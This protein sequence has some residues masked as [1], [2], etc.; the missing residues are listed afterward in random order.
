MSEVSLD[1]Y[2]VDGAILSFNRMLNKANDSLQVNNALLNLEG[3]LNEL[4]FEIFPPKN[5]LLRGLY[6]GLKKQIKV[7]LV[8]NSLCIEI[9]YH[10]EKKYAK[11]LAVFEKYMCE[12][13]G[14]RVTIVYNG[15]KDVTYIIKMI[16]Y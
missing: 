5:R 11:N 13:W 7:Y 3:I 14:N 16:I 12:A 1:V 6:F 9:P 15:S 10:I 4:F 2:K 8:S